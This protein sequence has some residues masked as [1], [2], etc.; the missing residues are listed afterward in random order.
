V[1]LAKIRKRKTEKRE[2][3]CFFALFS[4]VRACVRAV[5]NV[6]K[7]EKK[8]KNRRFSLFF[9]SGSGQLQPDQPGPRRFNL[10]FC[11]LATI[12]VRFCNFGKFFAIFSIFLQFSLT[13]LLRLEIYW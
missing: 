7:R 1:E 12:F 3:N 8:E 9:V 11:I 4:C 5:D 6:V 13:N 2:K 10:F